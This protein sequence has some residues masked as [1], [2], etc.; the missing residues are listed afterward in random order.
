VSLLQDLE[1]RGRVGEIAVGLDEDGDTLL[2]RVLADLAQPRGDVRDHGFTRHAFLVL[3][4][5][6]AHVRC[7]ERLREVDE[8]TRFVELRGALR[9]VHL[10]HVG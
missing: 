7:V 2:P 10:M 3:V 4:S 9:R 6:H 8:A 1:Q 5:K